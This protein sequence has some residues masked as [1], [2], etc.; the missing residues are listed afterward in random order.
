ME[1]A[2]DNEQ[3][4][5]YLL[6]IAKIYYRD[7]RNYPKARKYALDAAKLK[8]GW[9]EPY[10]L[11]GNLYASSGPLCGTGRGWESQVV[12]WPAIDMWTKAKNI[13]AKS[14]AEANALINRYR[15][16]MP[17]KEDIFFRNKKAGESYFVPCW[18]Q[19]NTIIRTSD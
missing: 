7:V 2:N 8:S 11:I 14:T 5:R 15:Q 10:L 19:E 16:Y 17:N 3:K 12:T 1:Q 18:I 6:L 13:D 4:A 9:G